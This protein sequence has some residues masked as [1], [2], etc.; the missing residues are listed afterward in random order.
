VYSLFNTNSASI[1]IKRVSQTTLPVIVAMFL[2]N[3]WKDTDGEILRMQVSHEFCIF[4]HSMSN[5]VW[6]ADS[7]TLIW[8]TEIPLLIA[9]CCLII[10][11][12]SE[13]LWRYFE[14]LPEFIHLPQSEFLVWRHAAKN[15]HYIVVLSSFL[16]LLTLLFDPFASALLNVQDTLILRPGA[17]PCLYQSQGTFL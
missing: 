11:V 12:I 2:A 7:H 1:L 3:S 15:K 6:T 8:F 9:V 4:N 13:F 14:L 17:L 16:G 10:L 5:S